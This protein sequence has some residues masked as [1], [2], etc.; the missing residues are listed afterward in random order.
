[1]TRREVVSV[2][3][4]FGETAAAYRETGQGS[5]VDYAPRPAW[6]D[7]TDLDAA[8]ASL[9]GNR[10]G[11]YDPDAPSHDLSR[12]QW[13]TP[14][15]AV[16]GREVE[17]TDLFVPDHFGQAVGAAALGGSAETTPQ[18]GHSPVLAHQ[19]QGSV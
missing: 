2:F 19:L 5:T 10:R 16:P 4:N 9:K 3:D 18:P 14:A 13:E 1:M 7:G 12:P 15:A 6:I 11:R 8:V 17:V